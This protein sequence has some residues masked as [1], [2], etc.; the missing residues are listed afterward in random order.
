M[1]GDRL[2]EES[3]RREVLSEYLT[4]CFFAE[5]VPGSMDGNSPALCR[6]DQLFALISI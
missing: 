4:I 5:T 6:I 3:R 2:E 1:Y